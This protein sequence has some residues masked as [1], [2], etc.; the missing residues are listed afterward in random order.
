[1]A[2]LYKI[3]KKVGNLYLLDLLETIKVHFVFSLDQLQKAS[4]D[5][6]PEQKNNPLLPVQVN[7]NN[8]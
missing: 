2:G 5:P 4:V 8:E 1:M 3:L 6:L 7:N